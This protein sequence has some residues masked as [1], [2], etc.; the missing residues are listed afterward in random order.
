MKLST[1]SAVPLVITVELCV[2][3]GI[4]GELKKKNMVL[5]SL[6]DFKA[7][8]AAVHTRLDGMKHR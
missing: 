3:Q 1:T 2:G 7:Q 8:T 6:R 5:Y 4:V